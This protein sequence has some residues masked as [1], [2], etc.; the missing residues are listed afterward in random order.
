M[1]ELRAHFQQ[2]TNLKST[3]KRQ[4]KRNEFQMSEMP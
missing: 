3:T 1:L 4:K 2:T